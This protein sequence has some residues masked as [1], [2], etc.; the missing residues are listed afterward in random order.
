MR[1]SKLARNI[2]EITFHH[3]EPVYLF[4]LFSKQYPGINLSWLPP[5]PPILPLIS[6]LP[7]WLLLETQSQGNIFTVL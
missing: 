7:W 5:S 3:L 4:I 2:Y 1:Q 6:S